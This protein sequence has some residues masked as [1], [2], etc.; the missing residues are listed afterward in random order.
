MCSF[1]DDSLLV[2]LVY[3]GVKNWFGSELKCLLTRYLKYSLPGLKWLSTIRWTIENITQ[4]FL[5]KVVLQWWL[6]KK[7]HSFRN[8]GFLSD[9]VRFIS[10]FT[11]EVEGCNLKIEYF[12][13]V[14]P[15]IALWL[16]T[17]C[18][19]QQWHV[20]FHWMVTGFWEWL[21]ASMF[22]V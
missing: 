19:S 22:L 21:S 13:K 5:Q 9:T 15:F 1:K 20:L 17:A 7:H 2:R 12:W 4:S 18:I 11:F 8:W 16:S 14:N 10:R 3:L 6:F